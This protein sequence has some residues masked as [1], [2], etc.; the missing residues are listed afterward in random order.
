MGTSFTSPRPID[1][2]E[3]RATAAKATHRTSPHS[4]ARSSDPDPGTASAVTAT[5]A[6]ATGMAGRVMASGNRWWTTSIQPS[7]TSRNPASA[8]RNSRGV[9]Q[10]VPAP[11]TVITAVASSG[12]PAGNTMPR[13]MVASRARIPRPANA[14][15]A[16]AITATSTPCMTP[17]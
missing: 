8:T 13:R 7:A 3:I 15:T 1:R 9:P 2:G 4:P 17:G 6:T 14:P 16:I 11:I 12:G 5:T 10:A